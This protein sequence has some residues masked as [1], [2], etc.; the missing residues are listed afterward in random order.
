[1]RNIAYKNLLFVGYYIHPHQKLLTK[2]KRVLFVDG[3]FNF[4]LFS[5]V[6]RVKNSMP[7]PVPLK[8]LA[9]YV[10]VHDKT[11]MSSYKKI[12]KHLETRFHSIR[13]LNPK[14]TENLQLYK[15]LAKKRFLSY[16]PSFQFH[17]QGLLSSK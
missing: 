8:F 2:K 4:S 5:W 11:R 10:E 7:I 16:S 1:M 6:L 13:K 15:K 17:P 14:P 9:R 12:E 3:S